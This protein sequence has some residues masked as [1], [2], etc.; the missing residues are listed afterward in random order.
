MVAPALPPIPQ[1]VYLEEAPPPI[2]AGAHGDALELGVEGG[3]ADGWGTLDTSV[4]RTRVPGAGGAIELDP[5]WRALPSL[6]VGLYGFGSQL[7]ETAALP[8]AGDVM[9]AGAGIQ[10][11]LHLVP[12]APRIDPWVSLGTGWRGQWLAYQAGAAT[13]QHGWDFVRARAGLDGRV[14]PGLALGPVLGASRPRYYT[15]EL[16]SGPWTAVP[17]AGLDVYVFGG[18]RA[19]LDLPLHPRRP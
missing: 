7:G 8:S 16:V 3:V 12:D 15:Q 17:G 11:T 4:A 10:G 18:V 2:S 1:G 9:Q 5:S 6:A 13:S 19:T 14:A